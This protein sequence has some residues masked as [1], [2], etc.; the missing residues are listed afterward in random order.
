MRLLW[1]APACLCVLSCSSGSGGSDVG[2]QTPLKPSAEA[3]VVGH[4]VTSD[5]NGGVST[6]VRSGAEVILSGSNSYGEDSPIIKYQWAAANGAA[7]SVELL[8][9]SATAKSFTAPEVATATTLQY[10]L[11]V[12]DA[13]TD[14]DTATV[15]VDVEPVAD[16]N[17]FLTYLTVPT[18]FRVTASTNE[19]L[20]ADLPFTVDVSLRVTYPDRSGTTR[21]FE[22]VVD[23]A[24]ATWLLAQLPDPAQQGAA[25]N[26]KLTFRIPALDLDDVNANLLNLDAD[27]PMRDQILEAFRVDQADVDVLVSLDFPS[28]MGGNPAQAVLFVDV[29]G[30]GGTEDVLAKNGSD[31]QFTGA[32]QQCV[33]PIEN[34]T[35]Q[36]SLAEDSVTGDAYYK[37]IDP[38]DAK[39][40]LSDW[41][42]AN[43][44]DSK[45]MD[46]AAD[47][48]AV[49]TNNYDLGFGR[50][51]YLKR[52][53]NC[54]NGTLQDG[55][56]ASVVINYSSLL[57]AAKKIDPIIAV[58]ME[59]APPA[60]DPA[61]APFAKFYV[62]AA[63]ESTGDM[64][65]ISSANF[66]GRG[67]K[68]VPGVCSVCHGGRPATNVMA[69]QDYPDLG[70][71]GSIFMPWDVD[72]FL[73]SGPEGG[74]Q[75]DPSLPP[76][77]QPFL[78]RVD[79]Q[80][81][82]SY[83]RANQEDEL[84]SLNEAVLATYPQDSPARRLVH[85]WYSA[86]PNYA[87]DT[88]SGTFRSDHVPVGWDVDVPGN[89]VQPRELYLSVIDQHCRA[90]H[91]QLNE[92]VA[93]QPF[94]L[95]E[96]QSIPNFETY[97][98]FIDAMTDATTGNPTDAIIAPVFDEGTMP[99]ARLTADRFWV[100][101]AS[102]ERPADLL[103]A[104]LGVNATRVPG[105]PI[106]SFVPPPTQ[107]A[108][109]SAVV[110]DGTASVFADTFSWDL[111]FLGGG[112]C[113]YPGAP[114]FTSSAAPID[115]G[116]GMA[117]VIPDVPGDYQIDLSV[118]SADGRVSALAGAAVTTVLNNCPQAVAI[119]RAVVQNDSL[120]IDFDTELTAKGDGVATYT[121]SNVTNGTLTQLPDTNPMAVNARVS[122]QPALPSGS[123]DYTITD[124]D[125]DAST[126]T[127]T[128]DV[129]QTLTADDDSATTNALTTFPINYPATVPVCVLDG[130]VGGS[131]ALSITSVGGL[132]SATGTNDSP[133]TGATANVVMNAG[134][135][136]DAPY[137]EYTPAARFLGDDTFTYS[138]QDSNPD[139]L[140]VQSTC[141]DV[142]VT[143]NPTS[144][145]DPDVLSAI[146]VCTGCHQQGSNVLVLRVDAAAMPPVTPLDVYNN[147][148]GG[149]D[150]STNP[151]STTGYKDCA[152][153]AASS[154][155]TLP[156]NDSG[157]GIGGPVSEISGFDDELMPDDVPEQAGRA[158]YDAILRWIEEG[159][160]FN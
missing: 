141:A 138:I 24:T 99:L 124:S 125:G 59:Y 131:G 126:A 85:D 49:Y 51:M 114:T 140:L 134:V 91:T 102:G 63:D 76:P 101:A 78:S 159:A 143:V 11:T 112:E 66:D 127:V 71:L 151:T 158:A 92:M 32:V 33:I 18:T 15:T 139:P 45:V 103:A 154:I 40:T 13:D 22:T 106:A 26:P 122:F 25:G 75:T 73:F 113:P 147:I 89:S 50:D 153:P 155:L 96:M 27:D 90:C 156:A 108:R 4:A 7:Q 105:R 148:T 62:F 28:G 65:R 94:V 160:L 35:V 150:C 69:G 17:V 121:F 42:D 98:A 68:F 137:L 117:V 130:D 84:R 3:T 107:A 104:H 70:N 64:A 8:T 6:T 135:C 83:T 44:F 149:E 132:C 61:A 5:G 120:T 93:G 23:S 100:P 10:T 116:T 43:C 14:Q 9:R 88:L 77:D 67:E 119:D 31:C 53:E 82:T 21:V 58:A 97:Q 47:S 41:L 34:M 145:F 29:E 133:A 95:G 81:L 87:S 1:L 2:N 12:T 123:F 38:F 60:Q 152:N 30:F 37:T 56:L 20:I 36:D 19:T 57:L 46:Y 86:N 144:E 129:A 142:T 54:A 16:Q 110:L 72:S 48:H 109:G 115:Y 39:T 157:H 55:E 80:V 136:G 128:V 118:T 146:S 52:G 111:Q 79:L 74:P